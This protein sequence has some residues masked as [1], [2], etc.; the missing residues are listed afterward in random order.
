MVTGN[1][2]DNGRFRVPTLRNIEFS[3]PYM[4]DGRFET[5]EEVIEH[6]NSGGHFQPNKDVLITPLNLSEEQKSAI[7]S[8]MKTLSD[9]DFLDAEK[10]S[11]PNK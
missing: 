3:A 4:H 1:L 7:I 5:L 2:I 9:P 11:D 10:Y 8:F 6:Y